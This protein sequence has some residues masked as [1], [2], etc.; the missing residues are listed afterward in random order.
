[1]ILWF[2]IKWVYHIEELELKECIEYS[3][4]TSSIVNT[5]QYRFGT[6]STRGIQSLRKCDSRQHSRLHPTNQLL[7]I[8]N[9]ITASEE[10]SLN[11]LPYMLNKLVQR[12]S[13]TQGSTAWFGVQAGCK[14]SRHLQLSYP[15][16][17]NCNGCHLSLSKLLSF[18]PIP[19]RRLSNQSPPQQMPDITSQV[20]LIS[21]CN[22]Q[23]FCS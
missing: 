17:A 4:C 21:V 16:S 12:A 7:A 14:G 10:I 13:H 19:C 15:V 3:Q 11:H 9:S 5:S 2:Q 6:C 18:Q 23:S 22:V 1:M 8:Y 20:I